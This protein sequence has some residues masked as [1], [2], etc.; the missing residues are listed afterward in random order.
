M[1]NIAAQWYDARSACAEFTGCG[2]TGVFVGPTGSTPLGAVVVPA[3]GVPPVEADGATLL[4]ACA[5]LCLKSVSVSPVVG[6]NRN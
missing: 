2:V 6:L 5:A 4:A 1:A 3:P